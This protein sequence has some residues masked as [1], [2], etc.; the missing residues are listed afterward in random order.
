MFLDEFHE[1]WCSTQMKAEK[2]KMVLHYLL[3]AVSNCK[4]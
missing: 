3:I 1:Y 2:A 4:L